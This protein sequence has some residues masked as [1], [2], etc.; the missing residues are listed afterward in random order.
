MEEVF[1]KAAATFVDWSRD[2]DAA[3]LKKLEAFGVK[4]LPLSDAERSA[5]AKE[6]RAV[7]WP[8]LEERL[9]K[10]VLTKI[11]ADI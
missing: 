10:D 1:A 7:T 2:N 5:I 3:N 11:V 8:K 9:G 4:V 6:I